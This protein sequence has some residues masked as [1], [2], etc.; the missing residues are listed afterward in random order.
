MT[1]GEK[2]LFLFIMEAE[3]ELATFDGGNDASSEPPMDAPDSSATPSNDGADNPPELAT[4]EGGDVGGDLESFDGSSDMGMGDESGG[5]E[6]ATDNEGNNE[7]E[8]VTDKVNNHLNQKLYEQLCSRNDEIEKI[9]DS[10]QTITPVLSHEVVDENNKYI[11]KL[12]A[13]LNKSKDYA[14]S[15]F[16]DGTYGENL[17]FYNDINVLFTMICDELDKNLKKNFDKQKS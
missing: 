2:N 13:A 15:K 8:S 17:A 12:K 16:I 6:E 10:M 4:D 14:I 3:T 5:G 7:D 11:S 9:L 1:N